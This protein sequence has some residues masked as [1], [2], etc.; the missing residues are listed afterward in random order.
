MESYKKRAINIM[1]ENK[2]IVLNYILKSVLLTDAGLEISQSDDIVL[3][4]H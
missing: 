2:K 4:I 3:H 1:I